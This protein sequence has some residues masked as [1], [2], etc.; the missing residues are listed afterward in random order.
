MIWSFFAVKYLHGGNQIQNIQQMD[1]DG[2]IR[3]LPIADNESS[4]QP[5]K[6]DQAEM[7]GIL[8][9]LGNSLEKLA[10]NSELQTSTL[11][12]IQDDLLLRFDD[13]DSEANAEITESSEDNTLD[14]ARAIAPGAVSGGA[15]SKDDSVPC[16]DPGSQSSGVDRLTQAFT[17]QKITSPPI[18]TQVAALINNMLVGGLS[19]EM[20][21]ER[22]EKHPPPENCENL[23]VITVNEEVWDLLPRRSRSVD[24]AF[25]AT[26]L[27]GTAALTNLVGS[28]VTN[29]ANGVTPNTCDLLT[30]IMDSIALVDNT[31]WKLNMKR[32]ELINPD[33]NPPFARLCREEI[34]P[35]LKLFGDDLPKHMKDMSEATKVGKQMQKHSQDHRGVCTVSQREVQPL[36]WL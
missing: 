21:K 28:L 27:Q 22:V 1:A 14:V 11:Q 10:N 9:R 33:L 29:I 32:W 12:N 4:S 24:Q 18:E 35:T 17:P 26:M 34:K 25:Q 7:A 15:A 30:H 13:N 2:E 6:I 19:A 8:Q 20:V 16:P 5:R 3:S 23:A 36:S 31:N